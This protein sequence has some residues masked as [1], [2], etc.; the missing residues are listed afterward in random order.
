MLGALSADDASFVPKII[1]LFLD[2]LAERIEG[3]RVAAATRDGNAIKRIA[4]A[5]KGSCGH[6]GANHLATLCRA[7]EQIATQQPMG[8]PDDALR[9]LI[10]EADRVRIALQAAKEQ[11]GS[12]TKTEE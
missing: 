10:A 1:E 7:L 2:D 4:H 11:A 12:T 3:L 9:G 8:D 5:L 6:F